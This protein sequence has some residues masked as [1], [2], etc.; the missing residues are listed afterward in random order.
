M[1]LLREIR[2]SAAGENADVPTLLRKCKIL[3][4]RLE[5][6][7]LGKW[8]DNELNGYDSIDNL[9]EYRVFHTG[10]Y[11]NFYGHGDSRLSNTPIPPMCF[12]EKFKELV[13]VCY[14]VAPI[15]MYVSLASK[16]G[17]AKE[18]LPA[19]FIAAYSDKLHREMICLEAWKMIPRNR[20]VGLIDT[21]KTRVLNFVLEIEKKNPEAG[22]GLPSKSRL[23]P[24]QVSQVFNITIGR[25]VGNIAAGSTD[26]SQSVG[27]Q[28]VAGD[29]E[30]L[31]KFLSDQ[32]VDEKDI[33]ELQESIEKDAQGKAS[34]SFGKNVSGWLSKQVEKAVSGIPNAAAKVS[35]DVIT[36]AI[37]KY[38]GL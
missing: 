2:N 24:E 3:A 29:I 21:I 23:P 37:F 26:F 4:V 22:D 14:L 8:V 31:K 35:L 13:S 20:L 6:D 38:L 25:N 33:D 5:S 11:G 7:E 15:S 27:D 19:D 30:T 34:P 18:P 32:G 1:S 10:V 12:P 28:I 9:P 17:D 36:K 16:D